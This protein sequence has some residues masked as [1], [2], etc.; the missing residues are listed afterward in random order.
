MFNGF[1][2]RSL[3][4]SSMD[5]STPSIL[6]HVFLSCSIL[7]KLPRQQQLTAAVAAG[8]K[9]HRLSSSLVDGLSSFQ[10]M[11]CVDGVKTSQRVPE[12]VF[13]RTYRSLWVTSINLASLLGAQLSLC[14]LALINYLS[15]FPTVA[16]TLQQMNLASVLASC[17]GAYCFTK[18]LATSQHL[19][20]GA[21]LGNDADN[22]FYCVK[23]DA[24]GVFPLYES[25]HEQLKE[26]WR[27]VYEYHTFQLNSVS[28]DNAQKLEL[29]S[30][31]TGASLLQNSLPCSFR[32]VAHVVWCRYLHY[33][34]LTHRNSS[35]LTT[36][37]SL[38]AAAHKVTESR[39]GEV[40]VR[41]YDRFRFVMESTLQYGQ[42][43]LLEE[44]C[45]M[46]RILA[47]LPALEQKVE[48]LSFFLESP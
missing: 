5:S 40:V 22:Q 48:R 19:E 7:A 12:S 28:T 8:L 47:A 38:S 43:G 37:A 21:L 11:L 25:S 26:C 29:T 2:S 24:S 27:P 34:Y 23:E 41:Y 30:S 46:T 4:A 18:P 17:P 20:P 16:R 42:L 3:E 36:A 1:L 6:H 14:T 44:F 45:S 9:H 33:I 15:I 10:T 13:S 35:K 31:I 39:V 32:S